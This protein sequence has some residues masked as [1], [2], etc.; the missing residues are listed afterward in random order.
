MGIHTV[1]NRVSTKQ[2][3]VKDQWSVNPSATIVIPA[4]AADLD[5]EDVVFPTGF[6][7]DGA[8]IQSIFMLI[9]WRLQIDSS[10]APNGINGVDKGIRVK[11]STGA[12]GT[13]D[14]VA[15]VFPDNS[16]YTAASASEPGITRMGTID[17]TG[18]VDS[19][20]NVTYNFRTEETHAGDAI[21]VDGASLTLYDVLTGMR[22]YYTL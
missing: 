11:K 15:M 7:E 13:D 2:I 8:K 12:W 18:E 16:L 21:L 10:A 14:I 22:V 4:V 5:F 3:V 1:P 20:E 9:W 6:L 17:L 19:V